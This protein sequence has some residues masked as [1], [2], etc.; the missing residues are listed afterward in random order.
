MRKNRKSILGLA[1]WVVLSLCACSGPSL[2]ESSIPQS[3]VETELTWNSTAFTGMRNITALQFTADMGSGWNLGNTLDANGNWVSGLATETCWGNP[4]TTKAMID[5]VRQQGFKTMRLPV[6]WY[7][8]VGP[9]PEFTIDAAWLNRV[10]EVANYAFANN[11]YVILNVHHDDSWCVPTYAKETAAKNQLVKIW[12]QLA[13]RFKNYGDYLIF[14]TLNEPRLVDSP[15]EWSGGT[16]EGRTVVNRLNLAAVNAIRATGGNNASRFIMVPGYAASSAQVVIDSYVVPNNDNRVIVSCHNYYPYPFTM[17]I[18][19][20]TTWGTAA[21]KSAMDGEMERLKNKFIANG[22]AV[23]MGEWGSKNKNNEYQR[24]VHADYFVRS[25]KTRQ[26]A[27]VVWDD[28]GDYIQLD[29]NAVSWKFP[30]IVNAIINATGTSGGGTGFVTMRKSN[31]LNFGIDGNNGGADGQLCYLW[32]YDRNNVN[33]Q[34]DEI[35]RGGGYYSYQKRGTSYCLDGG[36]GGANGQ[37]VYLWTRND[38]NQNQHWKKVDLG[39][40]YFRLEKR[41]SPGF[42]IDGGN[43]GANGQLLKLWASDNNN[44]NQRWLIQ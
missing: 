22:R 21:D 25:A 34:W 13:N 36:N 39:G 11:M 30:Q 19:G 35:N 12:T 43:G 27:V 29:R 2:V 6:T 15:E 8:H 16:A 42:S 44:Q 3:G 7:Q 9:A 4:K 37:S 32:S 28:G 38:G 41:N 23:V 18:P 24:S 5:K 40:G 26:I 33:Q 17:Q 31:A 14:E 20:A 1:L 10:E